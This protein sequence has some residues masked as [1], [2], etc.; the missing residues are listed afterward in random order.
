V[1]IKDGCYIQ[2]SD[3]IFPQVEYTFPGEGDGDVERIVRDL[4]QTGYDGGLSIEPHL[5]VVYHEDSSQSANEVRYSNYVE[6][7]RRLMQLVDGVMGSNP[8]A[9]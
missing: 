7:G 2:E 5:A 4:L 1:H 9:G 3:G 8:Q 6:Y